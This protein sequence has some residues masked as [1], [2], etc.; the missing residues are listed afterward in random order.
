MVEIWTIRQF[1]QANPQGDG[2]DNVPALLRRLADTIGD[3]GKIVV[4]D[5]TYTN[6]IDED[7]KWRPTMT[8]Y[9]CPDERNIEGDWQSELQSRRCCNTESAPSRYVHVEL[10]LA[11]EK[12]PSTESRANGR[13][14]EN[15]ANAPNQTK[16]AEEVVRFDK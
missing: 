4:Q 10:T 5:I 11:L 13:Y 8:V 3:Q 7:G 9:F 15:D 6:E 16:D 2:Q 14:H 1:S 12:A